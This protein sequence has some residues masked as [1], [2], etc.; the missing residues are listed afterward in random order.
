MNPNIWENPHEFNPDRFDTR[1]NATRNFYSW[2]P[3]SVGSRSCIGLK[4]AQVEATLV[5]A[6]VVRK[7]LL[8]LPEEEKKIPFETLSFITTKPKRNV[9]INVKPRTNNL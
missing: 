6:L 2:I 3:F 9:I 1:I 5:L 8:S 4:V 7:Y